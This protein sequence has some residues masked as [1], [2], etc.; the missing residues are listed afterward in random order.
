MSE[1][2]NFI[3]LA[4]EAPCER[5]ERKKGILCAAEKRRRAA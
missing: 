3:C 2:R 1:K 4:T 5:P